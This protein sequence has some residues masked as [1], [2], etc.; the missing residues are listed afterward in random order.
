ME[1]PENANV[2]SLPFF[3]VRDQN[4]NFAKWGG[5]PCLTELIVLTDHLQPI[6]VTDRGAPSAN[7]SNEVKISKKN[8]DKGIQLRQACAKLTMHTKVQKRVF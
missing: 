4:F 1:E 5:K 3:L 8:L 7:C 6:T 2:A